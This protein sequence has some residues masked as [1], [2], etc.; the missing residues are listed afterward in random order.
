MPVEKSTLQAKIAESKA[1]HAQ[2]EMEDT[3]SPVKGEELIARR[4]QRCKDVGFIAFGFTLKEAQ[5]DAIYT[6]FYKRKDLLHLAKTGFD[7]GL[8]F[9]LLPFLFDPT[10]VVI[11]L[12]PFKLLQA[13]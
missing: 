5:V 11:I 13:E 7:K 9:Q 8:I 1:V 12:M 4:G 2:W 6:L 10:G 3:I